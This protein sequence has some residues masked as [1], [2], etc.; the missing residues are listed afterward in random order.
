MF[1]VDPEDALISDSAE[2][3]SMNIPHVCYNTEPD[4]IHYTACE[5]FDDL[6]P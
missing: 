6:S 4:D 2:P 3:V 5:L 1:T